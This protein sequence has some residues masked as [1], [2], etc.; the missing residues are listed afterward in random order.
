MG[1]RAGGLKPKD[2]LDYW[3]SRAPVTPGE[4]QAMSEQARAR[5]FTVA[6]LARRDQVAEVHKALQTALEN[7]EPL[8]QFKKRIRP[9]MEKKGWTGKKAWRVENIYRTNTQQAYQAGRYKQMKAVAETRPYWRYVAVQD[10]RTR[11]THLALHGRVYRH[12]HKFWQ[13]W[14]PPNGYMCRCTVQT[15]SADQVEARGLEIQTTTP[16]LIEPI[17]PAT[18]NK[19]PAVPLV[20][21]IGWSGNVGRDWLAGLVPHELK[22]KVRTLAK[23]AICR[24]G[25]GLYAKGNPCAPPIETFDRRHITRVDPKD[26]MPKGLPEEEYVRAFLAEFGLTDINAATVHTLPGNIPVPISKALFWDREFNRWKSTKGGRGEYVRLLARAITDPFEVWHTPVHLMPGNAKFD[27]LRLVRMFEI[28]GK[29]IGGYV[30]FALIGRQW[31]ASTAFFPKVDR[32]QRAIHAYLD[33]YR[34]GTLIYRE[35]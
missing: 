2:A 15:L 6:G 16:R 10:K 24:D 22:G 32:S 33:K 21:D 4:Y 18:G 27:A 35:P 23:R 19:M 28:P 1:I 13:R 30:A 29:D 12:D 25:K 20:S 17:D 8:S 31:K 26:L 14:Y 34:V 7:G 9:L 5:A 11:P 3:R